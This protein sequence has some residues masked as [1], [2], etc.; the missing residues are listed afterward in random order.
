MSPE[1]LSPP[2]RRRKR[3]KENKPKKEV[4]KVYLQVCYLCLHFV[5]VFLSIFRNLEPLLV[6]C[7]NVFLKKY[8]IIKTLLYV[9]CSEWTLVLVPFQL[10]S[11]KGKLYVAQN[12]P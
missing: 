8:F 2:K 9:I 10:R 4:R 12:P 1:N 5:E 7:K 3:K 6:T 11:L